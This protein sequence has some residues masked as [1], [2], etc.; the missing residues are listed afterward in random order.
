M[1]APSAPTLVMLLLA[2][3]LVWRLYSRFRRLVGRQRLGKVRPWIQLTL[4]PVLCGLLSW[5][6]YPD[7]HKTAWLAAGLA[8]GAGLS[9]WGLKLTRFERT[10]EGLYYT[11]NG[12]LGVSLSLLFLGRIGYRAVEVY[13]LSASNTLT[14]FAISTVTL[15]IFGVLA[16]YYLGYAVGLLR[17]RYQI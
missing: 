6:V 12:V 1:A 2:P 14:A 7:I 8:A 16:G 3:L 4:F 11:P 5:L 15:A 10:P 9:L 13:A 17:W